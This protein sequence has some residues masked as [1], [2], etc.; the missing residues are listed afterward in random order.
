MQPHPRLQQQHNPPNDNPPND[1][2]NDNSQTIMSVEEWDRFCDDVEAA[3]SW[4]KH[5]RKCFCNKSVLVSGILFL[6]SVLILIGSSLLLP[7]P[8]TAGDDKESE[9]QKEQDQEQEIQ[10]NLTAEQDYYNYNDNKDKYNQYST[11]IPAE[12]TATATTTN[13]DHSYYL[14][15]P[16]RQPVLYI[17]LEDILPDIVVIL[18][19]IAAMVLALSMIQLTFQ[20]QQNVSHVCQ[21]YTQRY[22]SP[23][24]QQHQHQYQHHHGIQFVLKQQ[25]QHIRASTGPRTTHTSSPLLSVGQQYYIHNSHSHNHNNKVQLFIEI[26]VNM[27]WDEDDDGDEEEATFA[28]YHNNPVLYHPQYQVATAP[29][30]DLRADAV[31]LPPQN[32]FA[33]VHVPSTCKEEE[34]EEEKEKG[35]EQ[36]QEEQY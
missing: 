20:F 13:M 31:L 8:M 19:F 10:D 1:N 5:W 32:R 9:Q 7:L 14:P 25:Q 33:T 11:R 4:T 16:P 27:E 6:F 28:S 3:M 35:S 17:L 23:P 24:P 15:Q 36:E 2:H 12:T 22:Q 34:K 18:L 21:E 26:T 30:F 29:F